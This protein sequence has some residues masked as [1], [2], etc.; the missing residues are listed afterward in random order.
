MT[1]ATRGQR[2]QLE[3]ATET[4]EGILLE[5]IDDLDQLMRIRD[6][7]YGAIRVRGDLAHEILIDDDEV[8]S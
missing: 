2:I 8:R 7:V 4:V 5:D 6:Y 1:L 3:T